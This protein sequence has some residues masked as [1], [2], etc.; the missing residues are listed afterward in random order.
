MRERFDV[1]T[2][3]VYGPGAAPGA[4]FAG[5][6]TLLLGAA[7]VAD[8]FT[9]PGLFGPMAAA[10]VAA[11]RLLCA[12]NSSSAR[13]AVW[14]CVA[15]GWIAVASCMLHAPLVSAS[16]LSCLVGLLIV[17]STVC[18][19]W[20]R[21]AAPPSDWATS[22]PWVCAG[23]VT[24]FAMLFGTTAASPVRIAAAVA[25]ELVLIGVIRVLDA[26]AP[27]RRSVASAANAPSRAGA[28]TIQLE[29]G[30]A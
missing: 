8:A 3:E 22:A 18:R 27:R 11:E 2:R 28:G 26:V 9:I 25:M 30:A 10:V 24:Q 4:C 16:L 15:F 21:M 1:T 12:A 20:T 6:A 29:T 17:S 19:I 13:A 23:V 14:T 5:M 7:C